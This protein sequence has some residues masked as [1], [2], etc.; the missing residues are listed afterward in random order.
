MFIYMV[1]HNCHG[2][3]KF[4]TA[5]S[6]SLRQIKI[7]HGKLK[8]TGANSNSPW[9]IQIHHRKF[10][11][12]RGKFKFTTANSKSLL[13]VRFATGVGLV[14]GGFGLVL[15]V[16]ASFCAGLRGLLGVK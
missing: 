9:Q 10:K 3:L 11:I 16:R 4:T 14:L 5:N 15:V 7:H 12:H 8:F 1:P 6:N 13:T 2:K